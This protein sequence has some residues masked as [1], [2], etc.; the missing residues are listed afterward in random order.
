MATKVTS[1]IERGEVEDGT[2]RE[3][4]IVCTGE[5]VRDRT[6]GREDVSVEDVMVRCEVCGRDLTEF[7]TAY[8]FGRIEDLLID[9]DIRDRDYDYADEWRD[10]RKDDALTGHL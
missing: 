2:Y 6:F 9:A 10:R 7:L 8:E 1:S 5:V 4:G 3:I